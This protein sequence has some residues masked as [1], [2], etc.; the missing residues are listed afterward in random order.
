M[1]LAE[2][3]PSHVTPFAGVPAWAIACVIGSYFFGFFVRGAFGFGSNMPIVLL[4]T[5][6]LGPHHAIL[7]TAVAAVAAQLH[8]L[9]QGIA[10]A[11]WRVSRP[12]IAGMLLGVGAGTWLFVR[13]GEE[14]L[15][16]VMGVLII[17]IVVLDRTRAVERF[18]PRVDLR[19]PVVTTSL[20]AGSACAGSVGGGGAMYLLSGFLKLAVASPSALRGTNMVVSGIFIFGRIT[21]LSIAGLITPV[22]LIEAALLI[23]VVFLGTWAGTRFFC[24]T[25]PASF[26]AALQT[27]LIA[28]A[29]A[30]VVKGAIQIS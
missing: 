14:W 3:L 28:A 16:L 19:S 17:T 29:L 8:L 30:L 7:L 2:L 4:T 5:W 26:Y 12:L 21:L 1:T 24:R 25:G 18:A 6:L 11:D 15:T 22:L 27:L 9:P 10:T 20:A 23:P 13:L